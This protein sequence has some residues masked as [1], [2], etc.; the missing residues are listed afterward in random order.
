MHP[1]IFRSN[2]EIQN[3]LLSESPTDECRGF[4]PEHPLLRGDPHNSISIANP[5]SDG[6]AVFCGAFRHALFLRVCVVFCVF[7]CVSY[8]VSKV[9]QRHY[10]NNYTRNSISIS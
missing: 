6:F 4:Q 7:L 1:P 3:Q 2:F 9:I 5:A 10:F 8:S